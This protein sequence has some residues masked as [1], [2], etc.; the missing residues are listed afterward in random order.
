MIKKG[1]FIL[2]SFTVFFV[3]IDVLLNNG[4]YLNKFLFI[5]RRNGYV[6]ALILGGIGC[7]FKSIQSRAV[8]SKNNVKVFGCFAEYKAFIFFSIMFFLCAMTLFFLL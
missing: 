8:S 2:L 4:E 6:L 7:I 5:T 1:L 3:A